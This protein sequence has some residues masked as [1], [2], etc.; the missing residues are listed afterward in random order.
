MTGS[1]KTPKPQVLSRSLL[2]RAFTCDH[3][4]I[5]I[6]ES[7]ATL[8]RAP[9]ASAPQLQ[10]LSSEARALELMPTRPILTLKPQV[11]G[12]RSKYPGATKRIRCTP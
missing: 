4:T 12:A 1:G 2:G 6:L 5:L 9:G 11:V 7:L 8:R 3:Y 10:H